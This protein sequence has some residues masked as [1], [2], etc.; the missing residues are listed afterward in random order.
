M[1][2]ENKSEGSDRNGSLSQY[3]MDG[4]SSASFT[5]EFSRLVSYCVQSVM[6]SRPFLCIRFLLS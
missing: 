4:V 6:S 1:N 2:Q 5:D 3:D